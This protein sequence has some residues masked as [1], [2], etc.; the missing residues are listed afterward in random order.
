MPAPI[1]SVVIP[2]FNRSVQVQEAIRSV[3]TQGVEGLE[4]IVV[5][6][7]SEQDMSLVKSLVE[8]RRGD[9]LR[10]EQRSGVAAARNFG[11]KRAKGKWLAFLD[12][13]DIWLEG[14]LEKQLAFH[15]RFPELKVSQTLERWIRNGKFVNSGLRHQPPSENEEAVD[16]FRR[17]LELCLVSPSSVM[18]EHQLFEQLGGFKE[19]LRVCEDYD[20]WL[21]LCL[22]ERVGLVPEVLI[23]KQGGH[24]DQLSRSEAAIDRFRLY[25]IMRLVENGLDPDFEAL[26]MKTLSAKSEILLSGAEKRGMAEKVE[27]YS[28]ILRFSKSQASLSEVVKSVPLLLQ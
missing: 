6:D 26:A 12:S 20:L 24:A 8:A 17:F 27:V 22:R 11:V 9:Y 15:L 2:V 13:D 14:K 16:V 28:S 19:E 10:L 18:I 21:R 4:L 1:V 25:S 7:C 23:E 3:F 5:D